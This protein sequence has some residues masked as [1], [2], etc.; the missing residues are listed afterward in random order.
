MK[1][2]ILLLVVSANLAN[3]QVDQLTECRLSLLASSCNVGSNKNAPAGLR[4]GAPAAC[5]IGLDLTKKYLPDIPDEKNIF[6]AIISI[7]HYK[8]SDH[9]E[10]IKSVTNCLKDINSIQL[11]ELGIVS[12]KMLET[13]EPCNKLIH[14]P[15]AVIKVTNQSLT[16]DNFI[17]SPPKNWIFIEEKNF[18]DHRAFI[19]MDKHKN[20]IILR[21]G[22]AQEQEENKSHAKKMKMNTKEMKN[23]VTQYNELY[24]GE[25]LPTDEVLGVNKENKPFAM[26]NIYGKETIAVITI[27]QVADEPKIMKTSRS[28]MESFSWKE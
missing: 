7:E 20:K 8:A 19:Y 15:R 18:K 17:F 14:H 11:C 25:A 10:S 23:H 28:I 5:L 4:I 22:D 12:F 6:K 3:A 16:V 13:I 27:I 2:L 24:F 21:I 1:Y 26:Y 9:L